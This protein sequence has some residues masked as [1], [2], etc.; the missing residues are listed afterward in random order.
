MN[1]PVVWLERRSQ[2][3]LVRIFGV[4]GFEIFIPPHVVNEVRKF[5]KEIMMTP[6]TGRCSGRLVTMGD[7]RVMANESRF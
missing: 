3:G 6:A 7:H 1:S 5:F 4:P 2:N